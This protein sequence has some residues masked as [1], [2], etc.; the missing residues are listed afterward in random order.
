MRATSSVWRTLP[1]RRTFERRNTWVYAVV[2]FK[3][4]AQSVVIRDISRCGMKIEFV[5]GLMPGDQIRIELMSGCAL[6]GTIAW[7]VAA[8]CGV[9]FPTLLAE[10][11]PVLD[12]CKRH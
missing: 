3:G 12:S 4:R 6:Q 11:D 10:D 8:Y 9:E 7:S 2:H 5:Y 1:K